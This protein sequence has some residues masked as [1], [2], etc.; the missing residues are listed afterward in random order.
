M[1]KFNTQSYF[2]YFPMSN[3]FIE[4]YMIKSNPN[5]V[6]IYIYILKKTMENKIINMD[7]I[8]NNLNLLSS[9]IVKSLQYWQNNNLIKFT[10]INNII[11]IE[12]F[13]VP[14]NSNNNVN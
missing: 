6:I 13:E 14:S 5:F 1:N 3:E 2:P 4:N 11:D 8:S 7:E 10:I 9:D 12:Y